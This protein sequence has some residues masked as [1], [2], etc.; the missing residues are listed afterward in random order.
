MGRINNLPVP[1]PPKKRSRRDRAADAGLA[2]VVS[3]FESETADVLMRTSPRHERVILYVLILMMVIAVSLSAVVKLDRVVTGNGLILSA[4]GALYVSPLNAGVVR[5]VHVRV[6]DVVRAGQVLASLDPTLTQADVTQLQ[7][8]LD[9]DAATI[10]RLEAEHNGTLYRPTRKTSF[11]EV[12]SAIWAQRQAEYKSTLAT[13]DAQI[14]NAK[15]VI[16]Q[17]KRDA[18][19]YTKRMKLATDVQGMYEPLL[20]KGYVS[21]QQYIGA[22]DSREEISRLLGEA[23]NQISAQE[24]TAEAAH[25]QRGSFMQKWRADAGA[26]LVLVRDEYNST[27][28]N[29]EKAKK[30]L[31]LSTLTSPSDAIVLKIGK[32]SVGSVA[33]TTIFSDPG[34]AGALFTLVPLDSPLE[35]ETRIPASDVG[36]IRVG[37]KVSIKLDAYMFIRHGTATGKVKN[38][39]EGSFTLDD[40]NLSVPPYFKVRV[41]ITDAKLRNVP[42]DFRLIPGMTLSGDILVGSRTILSYLLEGALQAGS[43]AM[44]EAQ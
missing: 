8:K 44:R 32:V 9:S 23:Q 11:S 15:A 35:A 12:Q 18:E 41:G 42:T 10:E 6:G 30:M 3:A 31:E 14:G 4:G 39:S 7:Q 20:K 1:I 17:Y 25:G 38:I 27:K 34:S 28:E 36:F 22:K 43:E 37:D 26:Q 13:L 29:L 2:D 19:Q 21:R 24:Q 40:N 16:T 33:Q 5:D